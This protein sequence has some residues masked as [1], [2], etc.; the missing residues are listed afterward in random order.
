M[1]MVC[2]QILNL[3][4]AVDSCETVTSLTFNTITKSVR[5][6]LDED[7]TTNVVSLR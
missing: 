2:K 4:A 1:K 6:Y 3:C 7:G 5:V